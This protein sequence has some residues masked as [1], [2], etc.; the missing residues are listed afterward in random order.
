MVLGNL[1]AWCAGS[2]PSAGLERD[3]FRDRKW[4]R[5]MRA[6]LDTFFFLF[7][8]PFLFALIGMV[9]AV[10]LV[11]YAAKPWWAFRAPAMVITIILAVEL[12]AVWIFVRNL[13][14]RYVAY[15]NSAELTDVDGIQLGKK[16]GVAGM[17]NGAVHFAGARINVVWGTTLAISV[18]VGVLCWGKWMPGQYG[19]YMQP[20]VVM[21][22]ALV[23]AMIVRVLLG[24][25][26]IADVKTTSYET[27]NFFPGM[28]RHLMTNCKVDPFRRPVPA[29]DGLI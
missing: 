15:I 1:P 11:K 29:G 10:F 8:A 28:G 7:L 18:L 3:A 17:S 19:L 26:K 16:A 23:M 6:G 2:V 27:P 25:G 13:A 14:V 22:A 4:L 5:S 21:A 9:S 20:L 12:L 24:V